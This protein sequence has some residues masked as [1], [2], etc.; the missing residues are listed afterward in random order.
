MGEAALANTDL[1]ET[2][3][4]IEALSSKVEALRRYL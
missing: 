2:A 3:E 1:Q 4:R